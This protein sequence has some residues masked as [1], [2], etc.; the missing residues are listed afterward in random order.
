MSWGT[1][2]ASLTVPLREEV[3]VTS[4]DIAFCSGR[5]LLPDLSCSGRLD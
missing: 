5:L 1:G 3:V 4:N 2:K